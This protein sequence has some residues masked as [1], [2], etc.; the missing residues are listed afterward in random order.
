MLDPW[1]TL[2]FTQDKSSW[3]NCTAHRKAVSEFSSCLNWLT[4]SHVG[5][6]MWS[7]QFCLG[8]LL[9]IRILH[10]LTLPEVLHLTSS[11]LVWGLG[12]DE[13]E[14]QHYWDY[15]TSHTI[16]VTTRACNDQESRIIEDVF[17]KFSYCSL[18]FITDCM[19]KS[20][21][22][23]GSWLFAHGPAWSTW[24][25]ASI[26]ASTKVQ[27]MTKND[28]LSSC[29]NGTFW[30]LLILF[31]SF[32]Y[33]WSFLKNIEERSTMNSTSSISGSPQDAAPTTAS[34]KKRHVARCHVPPKST[35]HGGC[36]MPALW[37]MD[38]LRA[39]AT[40]W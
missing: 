31:E 21:C 25:P 29:S 13:H 3:P 19:F 26:K 11:P 33:V 18:L 28:N 37:L 22:L 6:D 35:E 23:S 8:A 15:V 12:H 17:H 38:L 4:E 14:D 5:N 20:Y 1:N 9:E 27:K 16:F 32:W 2:L 30:Y 7:L 36:D 10:D 24:P 34:S 39:Q 40:L